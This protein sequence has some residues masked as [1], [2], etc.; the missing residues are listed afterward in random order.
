MERRHIADQ[1]TP[2][3]PAFKAAAVIKARFRELDKDRNG[4]LDIDELAELLNDGDSKQ[5]MSREEAEKLMSYID[6]DDS[7]LV[8]F[9]E[10][11]D[12]V[13]FGSEEQQVELQGQV[14]LGS[15]C[16]R[17]D[18]KQD[19]L[20]RSRV[21]RRPRLEVFG[22]LDDYGRTNGVYQHPK[23][24][25]I[26][27]SSVGGVLRSQEAV[28]NDHS[29]F[30]MDDAQGK[31]LRLF[32]GWTF[33]GIKGWFIADSQP[34][35]GKPVGEYVLFNPS[36]LA[37][38]PDSCCAT[39]QTPTGHRPKSV[40]VECM[41]DQVS[42]TSTK[43]KLEVA[44]CLS[45]ELWDQELFEHDPDL[46]HQDIGDEDFDWEMEWSAEVGEFDSDS[47]SSGLST[48]KRG[49]KNSAPA[50]EFASGAE[51][52]AEE[53]PVVTRRMSDPAATKSKGVR[54]SI[55]EQS[56]RRSSITTVTTRKIAPGFKVVSRVSIVNRSVSAL[57]GG[58]TSS[59]P[60]AKAKPR[61]R[62]PC[63]EDVE[64]L[65]QYKDGK[66]LDSGFP[67]SRKALGKVGF[68]VDGWMRLSELHETPCLTRRIVPDNVIVNDSAG[69]PWFLSAC[70]AA[71]EYPAWISSM[72]GRA[73][74]LQPSG[75]YIV[76]MYHPGRKEFIRITVDDYVPVCKKAPAFAGITVDGEIWVAIV[77]KAFA[78][79]CG[80]YANTQWG[81]GMY[82][83]L[84][85][86]GSGRAECWSRE[87]TNTPRESTWK[88]SY[89]EWHGLQDCQIDRESSEGTLAHDRQRDAGEL[90]RMLRRYMELCYPVSCEVDP[91]CAGDSGL[92]SD[93]SYSLL[94]ARQVP[95]KDGRH[96]RMVFLRNPFG[97][98]EWQG[99][100]SNFSDAWDDNPAAKIV[101]RYS[102]DVD[103]TFWMSFAD[104]LKHFNQISIAKKTMPVQGCN[105]TKLHGLKRGLGLVTS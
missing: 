43:K 23:G 63:A 21:A 11:V 67:P 61:P 90:W 72:F 39:W 105:S 92:L 76:R 89:T 24:D 69:T 54:K 37:D 81:S 33:A 51:C 17:G 14:L 78:K 44:N 49:R 26:V 65:A 84:Y 53:R 68:P 96:L 45:A 60:K 38:S 20:L 93:R 7:G 28:F 4:M 5:G 22:G 95:A 79:L 86:C 91:A 36:P 101:L 48:P 27:E 103:G 66:F 100:W 10:F 102:P 47:D 16:D 13:F 59:A 80:S 6:K 8:S 98:C 40:F 97:I 30:Q 3:G 56:R 34:E 29:V 2:G 50:L 57:A 42:S 77:E 31:P 64:D 75:K 99:R 73:T 74:M 82:G 87:E 85:I 25:W 1:R 88:L 83:L 70:A 46:E 55:E 52:L 15:C 58:S 12:F 62:S 32:F 9:A 71:A 18:M 19:L 94:G 35:Q 104:F 41:G